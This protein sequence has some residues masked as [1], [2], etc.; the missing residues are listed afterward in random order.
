[1]R[2][3][4][5]ALGSFAP[6]QVVAL[7]ALECL[8]YLAGFSEK[9]PR[10]LSAREEERA[11]P[12]LVAQAPRTDQIPIGDQPPERKREEESERPAKTGNPSDQ[13]RLE[14]P[15]ERERDDACEEPDCRVVRL[16]A[17]HPAREPP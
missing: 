15:E 2:R 14:R 17:S 10:F 13:R 7:G 6:P 12:E 11:E 3:L 9:A 16:P 5:Q 8:D 1:M 4:L